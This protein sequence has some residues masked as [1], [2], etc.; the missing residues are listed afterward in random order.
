MVVSLQIL[1]FNAEMFLQSQDC[2]SAVYWHFRIAENKDGGNLGILCGRLPIKVHICLLSMPDKVF[3]SWILCL[4]SQWQTQN[5]EPVCMQWA[6]IP[7][8]WRMSDAQ[9]HHRTRFSL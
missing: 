3:L 6:L 5:T 9:S 2:T 1:H 8:C 7:T 4:S